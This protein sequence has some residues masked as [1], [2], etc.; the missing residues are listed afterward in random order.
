MRDYMYAGLYIDRLIERGDA[1]HDGCVYVHVSRPMVMHI[2]FWKK[3]GQ[4]HG[5]V[6][7]RRY[8]NT[9]NLAILQHTPHLFTKHKYICR[10]N[11]KST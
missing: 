2:D 6:Y 5:H 10:H 9:A 3:K 4:V 1:C 7:T 11:T 8:I